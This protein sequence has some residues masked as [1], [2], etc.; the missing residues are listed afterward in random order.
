MIYTDD[1]MFDVMGIHEL[2]QY[3]YHYTS[4]ET[5]ALILK[6]K[7]LRFNRLD[8]VNDKDEASSL[9][10][11]SANTMVFVSC[12]TDESRES[13]PLWNLYTPNMRGVR[14]KLP[15]NMFNGRQSPKVFERGGAYLTV[16]DYYYEI[17]RQELRMRMGGCSINGPNKVYY[18]DDPEYLK[19]RCIHKFDENHISL[20]FSDLG[21]FKKREW[22]YEQEWRFRI[23]GL[24][25]SVIS[26]DEISKVLLDLERYPILERYIDVPL[27]E[28]VFEELEITLGPKTTE[29]EEIIISA[30]VEKYAPNAQIHNSG[31]NIR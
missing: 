6:N 13:I 15:V 19:V 31:L 20:D 11:R 23:I 3:L 21:M 7:T 28:T 2:P 18:T 1:F 8:L 14:I 30:L 27:D 26:N 22:E 16:S 29:A 4:I 24:I 9:D 5:L 17:K 10:I 12:W 25:D